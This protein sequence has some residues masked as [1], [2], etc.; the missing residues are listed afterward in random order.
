MPVTVYIVDEHRI[1]HNTYVDFSHR[2]VVRPIHL[3]QYDKKIPIIAAT[4]YLNDSP[5]VIPANVQ[6]KVRWAKKDHT[7]IYKD[8]LGCNILR[9]IVY[10][11]IDEQMSF[12]HGQHDPILELLEVVDDELIKVGSSSMPFIIDKNPIQN[13]DVVSAP[14]Y[15]DLGNATQAAIEAKAYRDQVI[16]L[17]SD[18]GVFGGSKITMS[19]EEP[20]TDNPKDLWIK[21]F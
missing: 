11:D 6:I 13:E 3:V 21:L 2:K 10:F 19:E 18:I 5:Y 1:M 16:E 9:T 12:Y 7:F 17:I 4:L 20:P 15:D 8:V 14:F